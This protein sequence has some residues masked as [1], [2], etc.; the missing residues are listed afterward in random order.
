MPA[1]WTLLA[2]AATPEGALELRQRGA[3]YLIQIGGRVLMNSAARRSEE[4]LAT[5]GLAGIGPRPRVLIGGLGMGCTLRAALDALPGDA[6]VE[7]AELN[8]IV[9]GWCRGPLGALTNDAVADRRVVVREGDV[10]RF[11][12]EA[13]PAS[14]D[15]ILLDLYEGPHAASQRPDD[16]FF[17]PT[18]LAR[19]R[20]A[21]KAKGPLAIW[22]EILDAG[23]ERR[24][25][26]AGFDVTAHK[27]KGGGSWNH[28][29]Y[30][31]HRRGR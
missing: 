25:S 8:P 29:V 16:P 13:S 26:A 23:F 11:I 19:T 3:D 9:L 1:P 12:R 21:L 7:V 31:G 14:Y 4:A 30:L 6:V 20:N 24:F 15:A 10:S 28:I 22:A 18:A 2:T 27:I 17:G 5:L